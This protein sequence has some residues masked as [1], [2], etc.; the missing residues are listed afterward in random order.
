ML[1]SGH[2]L[3]G[4][5]TEGLVNT[6]LHIATIGGVLACLMRHFRASLASLPLLNQPIS[7]LPIGTWSPD[8]K[9][10][11]LDSSYAEV[12]AVAR[13]HTHCAAPSAAFA[14]SLWDIEPRFKAPGLDIDWEH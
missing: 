9:L 11:P 6:L 14:H 5:H 2:N 3:A 8:A 12:R 1:I 4:G 10:S 7:N 13:Q